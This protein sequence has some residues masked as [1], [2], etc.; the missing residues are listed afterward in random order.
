MIFKETGDLAAKKESTIDELCQI[1]TGQILF[2]TVV[3]I[4]EKLR[5]HRTG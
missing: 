3:L 4:N 5:L 1:F 2:Y